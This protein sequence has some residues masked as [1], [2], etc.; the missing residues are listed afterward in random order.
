[1]G[2]RFACVWIA[3][4][5]AYVLFAG[6]L[7]LTEAAAGVPAAAAS[8]VFVLALRRCEQRG[9]RL[10][11]P[12]FRLARSALGSLAGD[13]VRVGGVLLEALVHPPAAPVGRL[14]R[15]PFRQGG[16][17]P[18][19]AGRR[20]LASLVISVAP[21]GF[22]VDIYGHADAMVMHRLVDVPPVPDHEWPA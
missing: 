14:T 20:G 15:Q 8:T 9:L 17:A 13:V 5:A 7:S 6:Q 11:A 12:W 22:M 1:M 2:L 10:Q 19:D 3:F 18:A 16:A 4:A 21:N